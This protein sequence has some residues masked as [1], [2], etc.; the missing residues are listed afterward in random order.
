MRRMR[1]ERMSKFTP[2]FTPRLRTFCGI[3]AQTQKKLI[4]TSAV[5]PLQMTGPVNLHFMPHYSRSLWW[6]RLHPLRHCLPSSPHTGQNYF[7]GTGLNS[8][9]LMGE[10]VLRKCTTNQGGWNK[11]ETL[12]MCESSGGSTV[13]RRVAAAELPVCAA[14]VGIHLNPRVCA[15]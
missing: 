11:G 7:L 6:R 8:C 10:E 1:Q 12:N 3:S 13:T 15:R 5:G 4:T 14:C 9:A 2:P